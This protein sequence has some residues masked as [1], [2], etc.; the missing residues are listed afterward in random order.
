MTRARRPLLGLTVRW[1]LVGSADDLVDELATHV[2]GPEHARHTGQAGL[3]FVQWRAVRG[4]WFECLYLFGDE[5]SRERHEESVRAGGAATAISRVVGA[6]PALVETC[7]VL[8]L[9]EGWDGFV[10]APE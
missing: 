8:A 6:P 4:A 5:A 9:A 3:R 1:S 2:H 10:P 7:E